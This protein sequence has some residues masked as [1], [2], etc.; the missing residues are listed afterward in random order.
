M[1]VRERKW[2]GGKASMATLLIDSL[3][4]E[5]FIFIIIIIIITCH[6]I[7]ML[8][9]ESV[10]QNRNFS[11]SAKKSRWNKCIFRCD[12]TLRTS[13]AG[14]PALCKLPCGVA[15]RYRLCTNF[16]VASEAGIPAARDVNARRRTPVY[17]L[18]FLM[19]TGTGMPE[20]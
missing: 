8:N 12:L 19:R 11:Y 13:E 7:N 20:S 16:P 3:F 5:F 18:C 9:I 2:I 10:A 15:R 1:D 14:I 4:S 6:T 17:R